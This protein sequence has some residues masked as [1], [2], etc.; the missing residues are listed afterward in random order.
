M[1]FLLRA[2]A[3]FLVLVLTGGL[4]VV[5]AQAPA[6]ATTTVLCRGYTGC[7]SRGMSEAGYAAANRTMYWRMYA[8]HNCTNYVAY[9]MIKT[10]MANV[11][12]WSG[13]G[14]AS[15]W[16]HALASLTNSVPTVGSVAW[17]GAYSGGHG[18]AGHV[19]YVEQVV[20]PDEII[21]SQDS[22]GGDFSWSRITRYS[23]SWPSG[24]VHLNDQR[25]ANMAVPTVVGTAKVGG[26]L[27]ALGGT[28]APSDVSLRYVWKADGVVIPGITGATLP[29][30]LAQQDKQI[31]VR[32][33]ATKTGYHAVGRGSARTAAVL[34][35][36][37]TSTAAPVVTGTP[38]V[39]QTLQATAGTWNPEP[40][41]VA[42]QWT[43]DGTPILGATAPTFAPGADQVDKQLAVTV[44]ASKEGY[45][46][47]P[48]GSLP[49]LAVTPGTFTVTSPAAV[50]FPGPGKRVQPGQTLSADPGAFAPADGVVAVQWLRGGVP[51]EGA[52]DT[53]Y[54]ATA[55]DLGQRLSA[56]VTLTKPGYTTVER[57]TGASWVVKT[58]ATLTTKL[59][60]P[61]K[62]R[63]RM[64]VRVDTPDVRP[65]T[66]TVIV[67]SHGRVLAELTLHGSG[68]A[69]KVLTGLP[70]G[71]YRVGFHYQGTATV[72][73]HG[74]VR[75]VLV[76]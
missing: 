27:T 66:G 9:R 28:W 36:E 75:H 52:T 46:D 30:T 44:T 67:R 58:P 56:D 5:A 68:W 7:D 10:G 23:G 64:F 2:F 1:S 32:V 60:S 40:A 22:W 26:V 39:G 70:H 54:T 34:P 15:N 33:V 53:T 57:R 48:A 50:G 55:D 41:S 12:P 42:Y 65:V 4:G 74:D 14:N 6:S 18:S 24:F 72:L 29:L 61:R 51:I 13:D 47:V 8:G 63:M 11:R 25:I 31:N 71:H 38:Q 19:A 45:A 37:I 17:W 3:A 62:G 76:R 73:R 59:R 49:T 43:A 20:S 16:G 69:S 21:V 35:G